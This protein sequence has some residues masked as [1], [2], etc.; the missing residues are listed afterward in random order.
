MKYITL[1]YFCIISNI[2]AAQNYVLSGKIL[3]NKG[4]PLSY[5]NVVI[6][7][8]SRGTSANFSGEY[9]IELPAGNYSFTYQFIGYKS[10]TRQVDLSTG[11]VMLDIT[12][13]EEVLSLHEVVINSDGEDPAYDIIRKAQGKKKEY[14][15]EFKKFKNKAY[16]K[17]FA[18][19][20]YPGTNINL[21]GAQL[22]SDEGIFY[23]SESFS[24]IRSA[25]LNDRSETL[26]ASLIS[27]D[28][29]KYS[30][31][32]AVFIDFYQNRTLSINNNSFISPIA[33]DAFNYYDYEF[34]G[35]FMEGDVLVNKIKLIPKE[36]N[37][38]AFSGYIYIL[39]DSWRI[40][41]IHAFANPKATSIGDIE[42][43]VAYT[44]V[45]EDD[46]WLPFSIDFYY[47]G[48]SIEAYYH[49]VHSD[50]QF[51]ISNEKPLSLALRYRI[52]DG[53]RNK[54]E[55]YWASNRPIPLTDEELNA[56][57]KA[58]EQLLAS[59][60]TATATN[61]PADS[62]TTEAS[63][64]KNTYSFSNN[65]FTMVK[66]GIGSNWSVSIDP[67]I[68]FYSSGFKRKRINIDTYL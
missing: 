41:G 30:A 55:V 36:S 50:Y 31:N 20:E 19:G 62:A 6:T 32:K 22:N 66:K 63:S 57:A 2:V 56:Y 25:T 58:K 44:H 52:L 8:T 33:S 42:F 17:I 67:L 24:T 21:F 35:Y 49:S 38:P 9:E 53:A 26:T 68:F 40:Y 4:E 61:N 18:K 12:L 16:T 59:P 15:N 28:T 13:D 34:E 1:C 60:N 5:T 54:S 48:F 3:D 46:N 45:E 43:K 7:G 65:L 37:A 64:K 10:T 29:A 47:K 23:L 51:D 39:E 11:N 14:R 27:G